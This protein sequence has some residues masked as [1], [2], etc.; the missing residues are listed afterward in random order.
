SA[1]NFNPDVAM[2]GRITVVE[3]E[4]IVEP[5][6]LDPDSVQLSGVFVQRVVEVPDEVVA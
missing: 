4:R 1:Q 5:G 6:A 2:A 3:A